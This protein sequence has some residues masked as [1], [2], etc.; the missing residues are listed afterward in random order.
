MKR[1]AQQVRPVPRCETRCARSGASTSGPTPTRVKR[2]RA[3]DSHHCFAFFLPRLHSPPL[4]FAQ[5]SSVPTPRATSPHSFARGKSNERLLPA[6][7]IAKPAAS[8]HREE[9]S[10]ARGEN[11]VDSALSRLARRDDGLSSQTT[12]TDRVRTGRTVRSARLRTGLVE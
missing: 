11:A 8:P 1:H 2:A 6:P 7:L 10:P 4:R 12:P 5:S 3:R 9:D